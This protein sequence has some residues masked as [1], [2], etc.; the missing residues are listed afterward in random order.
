MTKLPLIYTGIYK[1]IGL[2][3]PQLFGFLGWEGI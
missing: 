2:D 1:L 3:Q